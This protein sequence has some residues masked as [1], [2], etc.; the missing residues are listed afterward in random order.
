MDVANIAE[1]LRD[2]A[3]ELTCKDIKE[4]KKNEIT[5]VY[6]D[7]DGMWRIQVAESRS[8]NGEVWSYKTVE[9]VRSGV[10]SELEGKTLDK[11]IVFSLDNIIADPAVN[12]NE[13]HRILTFFV[14]NNYVLKRDG[15][16]FGW[17]K[18]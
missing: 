7:S 6:L 17:V 12:A 3:D 9:M 16:V 1:K 4:K 15:I 2:I 8:M 14:D 10:V 18:Q 13:V 11:N 5:R